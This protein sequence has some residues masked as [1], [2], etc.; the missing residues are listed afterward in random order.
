MPLSAE[1]EKLLSFAP[2]AER[3]ARRKQLA[4]LEENGLRQS[5]YSRRMNE[6]A[7]QEKSRKAAYDEGKQWVESNR[8]YYK[9]ALSQRDAANARVKELETKLTNPDNRQ[10]EISMDGIEDPAIAAQLRTARA[11]A[12]AASEMAQQYGSKV[13]QISEMLDKG[14]L[15]TREQFESEAQKRMDAYGAAILDVFDTQAQA[16]KE[17]GAPIDRQ[18]LLEEAGKRGGDLKGAYEA[19]TSDLRLQKIKNE[20]TEEVRRTVNSEWETKLQNQG[21]PIAAGSPPTEL[22][23]MQQRVYG[24]KQ[25]EATLDPNLK[26]DQS[27]ALAFAM[28][29]ELR[30]EGK[31]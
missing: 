1:L 30:K 25:A 4:E 12:K 26:V 9:E 24:Q 15:I 28:A 14:Q 29:Q 11:E 19:V 16:L 21:N 7:E 31:Y 8:T 20:I 6:L 17:Y 22:G 18:R 27:G 10:S 5:D 23:P 3:E 2:E 13:S